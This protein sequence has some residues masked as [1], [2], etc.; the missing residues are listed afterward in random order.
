MSIYIEY[1]PIA[2]MLVQARN[3]K[4]SSNSLPQ[5]VCK[6]VECGKRTGPDTAYLWLIFVHVIPLAH[7]SSVLVEFKPTH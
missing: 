1:R 2:K 6:R 5:A 7:L 4:S 3:D